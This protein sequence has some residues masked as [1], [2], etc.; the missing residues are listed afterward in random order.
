MNTRSKGKTSEPV[1]FKDL[2]R[3]IHSDYQ[4]IMS[5]YTEEEVGRMNVFERKNKAAELFK[6]A[7]DEK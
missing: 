5:F 2:D 3:E 7:K 1:N 4:A 6:K